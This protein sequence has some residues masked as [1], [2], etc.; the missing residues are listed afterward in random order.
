MP[1]PEMK[2]HLKL[3]LPVIW[4]EMTSVICPHLWILFWVVYYQRVPPHRR[5]AMLRPIARSSVFAPLAL[6]SHSISS[7]AAMVQMPAPANKECWSEGQNEDE[8]RE[9]ES[10]RGTP[11]RGF[12]VYK[13]RRSQLWPQIHTFTHDNTCAQ[14]DLQFSYDIRLAHSTRLQPL[15]Y[16]CRRPQLWFAAVFSVFTRPSPTV[17]HRQH[18]I[19]QLHHNTS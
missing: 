3:L 8:H 4:R 13:Y 12:K 2:Q 14:T 15:L 6:C 18:R 10:D 16:K 11:Q 5:H 1:Q 19:P 17:R 7:A 9:R